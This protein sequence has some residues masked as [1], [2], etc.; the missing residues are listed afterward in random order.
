MTAYGAA[1]LH[2]AGRGLA[3]IKAGI[4]G[5]VVLLVE[6]VGGYAQ[7]FT[8]AYSLQPPLLL[9]YCEKKYWG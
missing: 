3:L 1:S 5:V 9:L 2:F 8:K 6:T 7:R 4:Y